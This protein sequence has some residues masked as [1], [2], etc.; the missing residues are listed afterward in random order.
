[1][2]VPCEGKHKGS[3]VAQECSFIG[4]D[5]ERVVA[6]G[7]ADRNRKTRPV[8]LVQRGCLFGQLIMIFDPVLNGSELLSL[9]ELG[10]CQEIFWGLNCF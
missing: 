8:S 10:H 1:M 6:A 3:E 9:H 5:L 2:T 4:S 7:G